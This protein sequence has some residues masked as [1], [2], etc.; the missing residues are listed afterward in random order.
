MPARRKHNNFILRVKFVFCLS[1]HFTFCS[2]VVLFPSLSLV[3]CIGI[4]SWELSHLLISE[5]IRCV[6]A[7]K[8]ASESTFTAFL[9]D[10][11][12]RVF[13]SF[14]LFRLS[15]CLFHLHLS[16]A[17]AGVWHISDSIKNRTQLHDVLTTV[18]FFVFSL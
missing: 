14:N 1:M 18:S 11:R 4:I 12:T 3:L 6:M 5:V 13:F 8:T 17:H 10:S 9:N 16:Y 15:I 2:I 7:N